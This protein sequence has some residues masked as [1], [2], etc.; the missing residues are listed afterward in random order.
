M[1]ALIASVQTQADTAPVNGWLV[2]ALVLGL[3]VVSAIFL[4]RDGLWH[5]ERDEAEHLGNLHDPRTCDCE[6]VR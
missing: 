4:V 2:L 5:I 6:A 3:C 1:T